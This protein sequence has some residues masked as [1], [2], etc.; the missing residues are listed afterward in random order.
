[1]SHPFMVFHT[2][3]TLS[4]ETAG[5]ITGL[6]LVTENHIVTRKAHKMFA[7]VF[8]HREN[9]LLHSHVAQLSHDTYTVQ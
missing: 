2:T 1:M 3:R 9:L 7:I 5:A 8:K 6:V 4:S